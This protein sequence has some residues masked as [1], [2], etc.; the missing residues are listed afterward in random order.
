MV[1]RPQHKGA[2]V[3]TPTVGRVVHFYPGDYDP[4][5]AYAKTSYRGPLT[6]LVT[7]VHSPRLVN[8]AVFSA[9]GG[10]HARTSVQL[11]QPED[12]VPT[13]SHCAWMPFQKEMA[14]ATGSSQSQSAEPRPA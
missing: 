3:I 2:N 7:Y 4:D 5:L 14:A 1:G 13:G 12:E 8:L 11:V 10:H 9:N 6:A